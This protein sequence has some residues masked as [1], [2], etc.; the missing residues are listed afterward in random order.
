MNTDMIDDAFRAR[1][2]TVVVATTG[3]AELSATATGY[4]R[5]TGSF[6]TDGFERG[7]SVTPAGFTATD[8]TVITSVSALAMTVRGGRTIEAP[9]SGR[10]LSVLLPV[11]RLD[12]NEPYEPRAGREHIAFAVDPTPSRLLTVP[13]QTGTREDRGLTV[14]QW[15][16]IPTYGSAALSACIAAL[17]ALFTPGTTMTLS[18][19]TTLYVN[20]NPGPEVSAPRNTTADRAVAVLKVPWRRS[21]TNTI[22]A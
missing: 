19:G 7:M 16:G 5:A 20:G 21:A 15:F 11:D 4:A 6:V 18:D 17:A 3:A 2:A 9:A 8:V 13:A 1:A 22:A 14:M 12:A 10:T